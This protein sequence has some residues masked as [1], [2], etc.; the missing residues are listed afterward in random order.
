MPKRK[1]KKT[2][3]LRGFR[4]HGHGNIK[5]RRGSGNKGGKGNAGLHKHKW[6]YTVKYAKDHFGS[7][8]FVRQNKKHIKT[9]NLW[10]IENMAKKGLLEMKDKAY[11]FEFDGKVLGTG[12]LSNAYIIKALA[13][14]E[15]AKQRIEEAGGKA[16][17]KNEQ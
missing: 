9:I 10:E 5:N 17:T 4:R 7:K 16:L 12:N 3:Y 8:G 6:T 14:S 15:K 1:K 2:A 11:I 13:F